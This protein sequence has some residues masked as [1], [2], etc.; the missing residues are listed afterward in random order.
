MATH[1]RQLEPCPVKSNSPNA[2]ARRAR[3]R[4]SRRRSASRA[5]ARALLQGAFRAARE[6]ES[7][8]VSPP[9]SAPR[10]MQDKPV[11]RSSCALSTRI[12]QLSC[13]ATQRPSACRSASP[14]F[15]AF[16]SVHST[17]VLLSV[18]TRSSARR[19][20]ISQ[21]ARATSSL[22]PAS[23]SLALYKTSKPHSTSRS[24]RRA[25]SASS[26]SQAVQ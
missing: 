9:H 22:S 18:S 23:A 11:A 20:S 25:L 13:R 12:A 8:R 26:P 21:I 3:R 5:A 1:R 14:R 15:A 24:A 17:S 4:L 7:R 19:L 2:R 10:R 16:S 6:L